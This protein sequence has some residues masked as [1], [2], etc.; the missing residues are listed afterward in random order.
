MPPELELELAKIRNQV[1]K[2]AKTLKIIEWIA[3]ACLGLLV[4]HASR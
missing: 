1:N 2:N 4:Y 3:W